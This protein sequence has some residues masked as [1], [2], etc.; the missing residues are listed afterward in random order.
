MERWD[1]AWPLSVGTVRA[2]DWPSSVPDRVVAEGRIGV[3]IGEP[4]Q[5]ARAALTDAL[6]RGV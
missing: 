5:A 3:A 2:G 4:E 1:V 6:A